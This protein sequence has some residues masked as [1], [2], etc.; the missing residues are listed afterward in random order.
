MINFNTDDCRELCDG[1]VK[2]VNKN[3]REYLINKD[4]KLNLEKYHVYDEKRWN[5]IYRMYR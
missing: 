3:G 1:E 4:R 5:Y 2:L